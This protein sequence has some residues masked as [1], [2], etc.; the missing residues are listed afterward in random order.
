MNYYTFHIGDFVRDTVH[1]DPMQELCYR[2]L[3]DLYYTNE[4]PLTDV[5]RT[6]SRKI[7]IDENIVDEVLQEFFTLEDSGWKHKRCDEEIAKFYRRSEAARSAGKASA[8]ARSDNRSTKRSTSVQRKN[9]FSSTDVEQTSTTQ[10]PIPINIEE[11]KSSSSAT[12][13][14]ASWSAETSFK[15]SDSL[16]VR[17]QTAYP[18]CD[19]LAQAARAHEWLMANPQK[20]KKDYHRFLVGWLSRAQERGGDVASNR[21]GLSPRASAVM[22][23]LDH[24]A[25]VPVKNPPPPGW[26]ELLLERADEPDM[27]PERWEDCF[28]SIQSY[29]RELYE[30]KGVAT[31]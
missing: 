15:I 5:Q 1:L 2:R 11:D 17:L 10:Y 9:N 16:L 25:Q 12:D 29:A 8:A 7:R 13:A 19:I 31:A 6:L 27:V 22:S 24:A 3:I 23:A 20:R 4:G 26:R 21:P 30:R 18:A 28:P 14:K